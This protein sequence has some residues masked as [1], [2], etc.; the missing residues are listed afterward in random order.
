MSELQ[1]RFCGTKYFAKIDL[2]NDYQL[3]HIKEGDEWKTAF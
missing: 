1:D 3:I 2:K